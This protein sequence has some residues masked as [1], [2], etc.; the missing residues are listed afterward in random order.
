MTCIGQT[1]NCPVLS[2]TIPV[3]SYTFWEKKGKG[4]E[5]SSKEMGEKG[6]Y[7]L[8]PFPF[9]MTSQESSCSKLDSLGFVVHSK[10]EGFGSDKKANKYN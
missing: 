8:P 2:K 10:E 5:I 1:P 7:F 9:Y 3:M 4:G 6:R